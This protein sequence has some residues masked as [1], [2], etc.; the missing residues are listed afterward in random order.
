[1]VI[2]IS[3]EAAKLR[4]VNIVPNTMPLLTKETDP[5]LNYSILK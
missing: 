4:D 2:I 1:M 5:S 3:I